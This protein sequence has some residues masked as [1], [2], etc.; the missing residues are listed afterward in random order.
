MLPAV[1][2][3][4]AFLSTEEIS[5][6]AP[7]SNTV[8]VVSNAAGVG[9]EGTKEDIKMTDEEEEEPEGEVEDSDEEESETEDLE[10]PIKGALR[11]VLDKSSAFKGTYAAISTYYPAHNPGLVVDGFSIVGLPLNPAE[12]AR[13]RS[14][15]SEAPFGKGERTVVDKTVRDT[16][17]LDPCRIRFS[18]PA[19]EPWLRDT[20]VK[21]L[22]TSLGVSQAI[23]TE[24]YKMLLYEEG[25]HFLPHQD[26]EKANGMFATVIVV[27][28][29]TF[30]GG[31]VH[32]SHGTQHKV[33][34]TAANSAFSTSALAWYTDV[35]HEV[36][37]LTS[38]FRLALS[39]NLVHAEPSLPPHIPTDNT[40][41][42]LER[43]LSA[44]RQ[45]DY[46]GEEPDGGAPPQ[47][48]AYLLDH[49]YSHANLSFDKLKGSDAS[50]VRAVREVSHRVDFRIAL[51]S[52]RF[53]VVGAGEDD[54]PPPRRGWGYGYDKYDDENRDVEMGEIYE[55]RCTVQ[56]ISGPNG[57]HLGSATTLEME[58]LMVDEEYF[59]EDSPDDQKYEGYQGNYA[60]SV[61]YFYHRTVLLIWPGSQNTE[62]ITS[63]GG[64][65]A[66]VA[67]LKAT[68]SSIPSQNDL[69]L[70]DL[71]LSRG[72]VNAG[73]LVADLAVRWRDAQLWHKAVT[74]CRAASDVSVLGEAH[75]INAYKAFGFQTVVNVVEQTMSNSMSSSARLG[76]IS[77]FQSQPP[78]A[79]DLN[80]PG[81]WIIARRSQI[82]STL[83]RP[84]AQDMYPIVMN[85]WSLGG[86][87][88]L[89]DV[90]LPQLIAYNL[91]PDL[92]IMLMRSILQIEAGDKEAR[93]ARWAQ[94]IFS[95]VQPI[96][97]KFLKV[98]A[99]NA[100]R[101]HFIEEV[102]TLLSSKPE[103][104][105]WCE[106]QRTHTLANLTAPDANDVAP[107]ISY[108]WKFGG[109]DNLKAVVLP[110]LASFR[111]QPDWWRALIREIQVKEAGPDER[112]FTGWSE[113]VFALAKP[114]L[115][116][117][118]TRIASNVERF[119]FIQKV[120]ALASSEAVFVD[121]CADRRAWAIQSLAVPIVTDIP[122]FIQLQKK[123]LSFLETTLLPKLQRVPFA[124]N[125]WKSLLEQYTSL[126]N[127]NNAAL[128]D[129][130]RKLLLD[131]LREPL[132]NQLQSLPTN[133][134]RLGVLDGIFCAS[135]LTRQA[136]SEF[137]AASR[138]TVL[139]ALVK[140]TLQEVTQLSRALEDDTTYGPLSLLPQLRKLQLPLDFWKSFI[141]MVHSRR[142]SLIGKGWE[143][144]NVN[145]FVKSLV[146][147]AILQTKIEGAQQSAPPPLPYY[148]YGLAPARP[149]YGAVFG[150]VKD[151]LTPCIETDNRPLADNV[152][153]AI[154]AQCNKKMFV[155]H[156]VVPLFPTLLDLLKAHRL[157]PDTAPFNQFFCQGIIA[158]IGF[159]GPKPIGSGANRWKGG[160]SPCTCKDCAEVNVL[161]T[162]ARQD[163]EWAAAQSRR[164][165]VET[166]LRGLP[167]LTLSTIARGSPHRLRIV[168][169]PAYIQMAMWKTRSDQGLKLLESV[170]GDAMWQKMCAEPEGLTNL[171]K[172]LRG[173]PVGPPSN[174]VQALASSSTSN[175]APAALASATVPAIA[176]PG[177]SRNTL[178]VM[179]AA[180]S[181]VLP[182]TPISVTAAT[183]RLP[184]TSATAPAATVPRKRKHVVNQVD[185]DLTLD[186]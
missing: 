56:L 79:E 174:N 1:A 32:V 40:L 81:E 96:F 29:S 73:R 90:V 54:G 150:V 145:A 146:E 97:E 67:S 60:G 75:L 14:V 44:W 25:S 49:R 154:F 135:A 39:Y 108:S 179:P 33:F 132:R 85:S 58:E 104:A 5:P 125:F 27:L 10:E 92:W 78:S 152:F 48:L 34:D 68:T 31:Q 111:L 62:V 147:V 82:L 18:N 164:S 69:E 57:E 129:Q 100:A 182:P 59:N 101:F 170:G 134:D 131:P 144:E 7:A 76:L 140:P 160:M 19:W 162:S 84:E 107:I 35:V 186:D 16:W 94:Q 185:I 183:R 37:P 124:V 159:L 184:P 148:G 3:P 98:T 87:K 173:E 143:P 157:T 70:A 89:Q 41:T 168:K 55:R 21:G 178:A 4:S 127:E 106:E 116:E 142:T 118:L 151:L 91:V 103:F 167:G 8:L 28:P 2:Q 38:G 43:V 149:P 71:A 26:T 139:D 24:F 42:T 65:D 95:A 177:P 120:E 102:A 176:M 80:A 166:K 130:W 136:F 74:S 86:L 115:E 109:L 105:Q 15:C 117:S 20:V 30:Q 11:D 110:Q 45:A 180:P 50:L 153:H 99:S 83:K 126:S 9:V 172:A 138:R 137:V 122:L 161:L 63:L 155:E 158:F 163:V 64:R 17:E 46:R 12:A 181:V 61:E 128:P 112:R 133:T 51:G 93:F 47:K 22:C 13:L 121:W 88:I 6:Q 113:P 141:R 72:G 169:S 36:K 119:N 171:R 123:D 175:V 52:L 156:T 53:T 114:T 23:K 66:A 165:H 77:A